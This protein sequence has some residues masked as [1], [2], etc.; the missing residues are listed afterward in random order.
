MV[1]EECVYLRETFYNH[2]DE[3]CNG[4]WLTYDFYSIIQ[5]MSLEK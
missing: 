1:E 4:K 3:K 5:R 2:Y